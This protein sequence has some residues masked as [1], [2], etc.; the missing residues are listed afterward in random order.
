MPKRSNDF[1][2][3]MLRIYEQLAPSGATVRESAILTEASGTQREV[4]I[5][6]EHV[7]A[8]TRIAVAVECRD[9]AR[10]SDI[11]WVDQL[12]GKY[13]DLDVHKVIAVASFGFSP[14]ATAKAAAARIDCRSLEDALDSDWPAELDR[15]GVGLVTL[16]LTP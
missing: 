11:E 5:L 12:I 13:R 16:V 2:R 10:V 8:D 14:A 7:V 9:R 3:L 1:Q 6:I 15:I 4:D